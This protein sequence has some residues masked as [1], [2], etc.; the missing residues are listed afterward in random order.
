MQLAADYLR[1]LVSLGFPNVLL[2]FRC[3]ISV[4]VLGADR[5]T[6]TCAAG[7]GPLPSWRVV[8]WNGSP[9]RAPG[10]ARSARICPREDDFP[11][12]C[13]G[14]SL[15]AGQTNNMENCIPFG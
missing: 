13:K 15:P 14:F 1:M 3:S 9:P 12:G 5:R 7:K 8:P 11:L 6:R 2:T 10:T 4:I